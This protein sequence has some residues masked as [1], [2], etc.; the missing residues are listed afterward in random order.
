[1]YPPPFQFF[2]DSVFYNHNTPITLALDTG[3]HSILIGCEGVTLLREFYIHCGFTS[4]QNP[5]LHSNIVFI[6]LNPANDK[7]TIEDRV[8]AKKRHVYMYNIQGQL[9]LQQAMT[10]EQTELDISAFANGFYI[11][12]L[13]NNE[14]TEVVKFVKE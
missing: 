8:P 7:I 10:Q 13:T 9:L 3:W 6:Y 4:I 11:L 5:G 2:V 1:V 12:K 14:K